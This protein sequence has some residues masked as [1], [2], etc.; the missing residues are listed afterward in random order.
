MRWGL[1]NQILQAGDVLSYSVLFDQYLEVLVEEISD[2]PLSE[3]MQEEVF[4]PLGPYNAAETGSRGLHRC[5]RTS[6]IR[7]HEMPLRPFRGS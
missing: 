6:S 5:Y 4:T 7:R 1:I 3:A 2:L